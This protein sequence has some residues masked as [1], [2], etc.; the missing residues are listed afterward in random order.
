MKKASKKYLAL[1]YKDK[2]E[3]NKE[4]VRLL[5]ELYENK[6]KRLKFLL[7][8]YKKKAEKEQ[9]DCWFK[10]Y[11]VKDYAKQLI[12]IYRKI[13]NKI[14]DYA[15]EELTAHFISLDMNN[16]LL[17]FNDSLKMF[18]DYMDEH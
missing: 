17:D 6:I 4:D 2:T 7:N 14:P 18:E 16:I 12:R 5:L 11:C 13:L 3:V 15:M 1:K 9:Y 10:G 8:T